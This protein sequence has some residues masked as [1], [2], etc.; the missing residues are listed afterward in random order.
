MTTSVPPTRPP[1]SAA[2]PDEGEYA[3]RRAV[4]S[5]SVE[6]WTVMVL[7]ELDCMR[8]SVKSEM[9]F[10]ALCVSGIRREEV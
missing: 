1:A 8:Y 9:V 10:I 4:T 2:G 3:E 6:S 7:F 5:A